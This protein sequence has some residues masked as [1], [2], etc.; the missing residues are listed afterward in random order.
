MVLRSS[1]V[2]E[3]VPAN[4][5]PRLSTRGCSYYVNFVLPFTRCFSHVLIGFEYI[6][7]FRSCKKYALHRVARLQTKGTFDWPYFGIRIYSRIFQNSYSVLMSKKRLLRLRNNGP[8]WQWKFLQ[9]KK[10]KTK[11]ERR[12]RQRRQTKD[13]MSRTLAY[14]WKLLVLAQIFLLC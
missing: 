12:Q 4:A 10:Q 5:V 6:C 11:K 7:C 9:K 3:T 13:L 8:C 2:E 14:I 1:A